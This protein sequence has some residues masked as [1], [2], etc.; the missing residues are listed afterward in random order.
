MDSGP[1][2]SAAA[3]TFAPMAG[4]YTA[5]QN[6]TISTTTAGATI[7]FT[8]DGTNPTKA[9]TVYG[10]PI[11]IAKDTT[12]RAFAAAPG[13]LDS[14]ISTAAYTITIPP[15]TTAPVDFNPAAGSS[16]PNAVNVALSTT[17]AGATICYTT[18]GA[19]TPACTNGT[20]TGT[21]ATYNA[22][23]PVNVTTTGTKVQ[24]I[25]C[26]SGNTNSTVTSATYGFKAAAATA[27]PMAGEVADNTTVTV[28]TVTV[29]GTIHY[30]I[31]DVQPTCLTGSTFGAGVIS[32]NL[33]VSGNTT[34]RTIVCKAGYA[35][36]DPATFA[37]TVRVDAPTLDT[38]TYNNDHGVVASNP[39]VAINADWWCFASGATIPTCGATTST[40]GGGGTTSL[41]VTANATTVNAVGCKVGYTGSH[42]T[43]GVYNLKVGTISVNATPNDGTYSACGGGACDASN[44]ANYWTPGAASHNFTLTTP[45]TGAVT[46]RYTLDN[47]DPTCGTGTLYAGAFSVAEFQTIKAIA[48]KTSY[49]SADERQL[50]YADPTQTVSLT[51]APDPGTVYNNDVPVVLTSTPSD[52]TICY[53]VGIAPATPTCNVTTGACGGAGVHT[54]TGLAST[55]NG[56]PA[57]TLNQDGFAVKAIACKSGVPTTSTAINSTY[58]LRVGT[59]TLTPNGGNMAFNDPITMSSI[60]TSNPDPQVVFHWNFGSP[61]AVDPTCSTGSV[62]IGTSTNPGDPSSWTINFSSNTQQQLKVIACA[63]G[64]QPS[65]ITAATFTPAS[66]NAPVIAPNPSTT[67]SCAAGT[68]TFNNAL[69][70]NPPLSTQVSLSDTSSGAPGFVMCYTTNGG[71]PACNPVAPLC[72]G[73]GN[74]TQYSAPFTVNTNGT[75]V[76]AVACA[77]SYPGSAL[78]QETFDFN[79]ADISITPASGPQ[80][81]PVSSIDLHTGTTTNETV[82]YSKNNTPI[83]DCG[84]GVGITC[85][86]AGAGATIH[87][88]TDQAT[89]LTVRYRA[90]RGGFVSTNEHVDTYGFTPYSHTITIDGTN[91]FSPT[92]DQVNSGSCN[93][94]KVYVSWNDTN[95]FVGV[96]GADVVNRADRYW[97]FYVRDAAGP[98]TTTAD[99]LPGDANAFGPVAVPDGGANWHFYWRTDGIPGLGIRQFTGGVWQFPI[100]APTATCLSGGTLGNADAYVECSVSRGDLG[101]TGA[102][103]LWIAQAIHQHGTALVCGVVDGVYMYAPFNGSWGHFAMNMGSAEA[104]NYA[105]YVSFP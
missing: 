65:P 97:H 76:K 19:T 41:T 103:T 101:L 38:G 17:T 72:G 26:K 50:S 105:G 2:M 49:Q 64:Y 92:N 14:P 95:F 8:T 59:P 86:A 4:A 58:Q 53:T 91:D 21:S 24:A 78:T 40:C 5:A 99:A 88:A 47:S 71:T 79:V 66:L 87:I 61:V 67:G 77:T 82:C 43:S 75:T 37:Y 90:C 102:S 44:S 46:I 16:Y 52:A 35:D 54:A 36:S 93:A 94:E 1:T 32:G 60:T 98:Y 73:T 13:F 84:G 80:G 89:N 28:S 63:A 7:Y 23:S 104:P 45:T 62:H 51:I 56:N 100:T 85:Q 33:N 48:C 96:Q 74:V 3:P 10:T 22:A 11:A 20:C 57:L 15:G 30:T 29:G 31:N 83:N 42:A 9:S 27:L 6:V 55:A 69:D 12:L 25:A 81:G 68:C 70:G 34:I 39:G 18:D